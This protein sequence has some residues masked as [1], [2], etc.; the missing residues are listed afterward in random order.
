MGLVKLL[1]SQSEFFITE[2]N[3]VIPDRTILGFL[4][5]D[6]CTTGRAHFNLK[7]SI[8]TKQEEW[9]RVFFSKCSTT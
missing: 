3:G 5:G 6:Y 7:L 9:S 2:I 1:G 4:S 8:A